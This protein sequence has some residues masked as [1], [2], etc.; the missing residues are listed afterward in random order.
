MCCGSLFIRV[1]G[2]TR[3]CVLVVVP[4]CSDNSAFLCNMVKIS[5]CQTVA[6]TMEGRRADGEVTVF[7]FG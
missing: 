4:V 2:N 1:L 3:E 5:V 7:L 6:V